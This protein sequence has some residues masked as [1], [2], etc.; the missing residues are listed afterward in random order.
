MKKEN[1]TTRI[2]IRVPESVKQAFKET[3]EALNELISKNKFSDGTAVL[4]VLITPQKIYCGNAGDSRAILIR[5]GF[6]AIPLSN[7]HK[8][9]S[10]TEL[11]RIKEN[12]GYIDKNGRQIIPRQK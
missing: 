6:E 2:E 3:N 8:P 11:K 5:R 12:N 4:T 9:Y 10:P 1:K 7:D